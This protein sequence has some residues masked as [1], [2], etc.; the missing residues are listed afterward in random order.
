MSQGNATK[1]SRLAV[2]PQHGRRSLHLAWASVVLIPVAFVLAMV[3]G[4]WLI[5]IQG[6]ETG[7]EEALPLGVVALAG[8]P[9]LLV[10][11]APTVTAMVFGRR[12]I[13]LGVPEGKTPLIIGAVVA[14]GAILLNLGGLAVDRLFF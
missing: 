12:A 1:E 7:S 5:T 3:L 10:M 6:Y 14:A 11:I 13:T 8:I 4:D 2:E 9:A